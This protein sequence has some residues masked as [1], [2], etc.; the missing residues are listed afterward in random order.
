MK[1]LR[2]DIETD[3]L[4]ENGK[5]WESIKV[6]NKLKKIYNNLKSQV[7]IYYETMLSYCLKCK[8]STES[9]NP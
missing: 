8:R 6:L 3:K 1:I 4:V 2:I 7:N 9:K 5:K